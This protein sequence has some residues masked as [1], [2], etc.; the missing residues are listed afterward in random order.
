MAEPQG[1]AARPER[2]WDLEGVP[3]GPIQTNCYVLSQGGH[4]LVVDPGGSGAAL[5]GHL[6]D[7]GLVVDLIV[8]THGHGDHVGGVAA[9]KRATG[10]P[11]A[12]S[13]ADADA[14]RH[15]AQD[16]VLGI[17]YDDDAPAPDRLLAEGDEV[18]LGSWRLRVLETPGHTPGGIVLAGSLGDDSIAFVGDTLFAGSVGRCDLPGG[19]ATDLLAS[20]RRLARELP[21]GC[22][23]L[24]GHGP[25]TTMATELRS[26]PYLGPMGAS[27]LGL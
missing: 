11:F 9:L 17:A 27:Y 1:G 22:T 13:A 3:L 10:A 12:M 6:S 8:A 21:E 15:A 19:S 23:V 18:A 14:A 2:T 25:V 16:P 5:A 7:E 26:N 4:A 20:V 24:P